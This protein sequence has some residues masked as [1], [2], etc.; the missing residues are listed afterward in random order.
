MKK[1]ISLLVGLSIA[2]LV[3]SAMAG[4]QGGP[5]ITQGVIE[6]GYKQSFDIVLEG[7]KGAFIQVL[8]DGSSDIDC[9]IVNSSGALV[10]VD[11]D[12]TD[13]CLF[14]LTPARTEKY[15]LFIL[16]RGKNADDFTIRTN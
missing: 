13:A 10:A 6:S 7:K 12:L 8:G 1:I 4:H 15:T 14:T 11:D 2:L 9:A 3:G 5:T 16:N